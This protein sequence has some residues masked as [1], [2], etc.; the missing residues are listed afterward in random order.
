MN[1]A[2][3]KPL[4]L[5]TT[6]TLD[7]KV[8]AAYSSNSLGTLGFAAGGNGNGKERSVT[9]IS[10]SQLKSLLAIAQDDSTLIAPQEY[11]TTYLP[12]TTSRVDV[13]S[14]SPTLQVS[15]SVYYRRTGKL[16]FSKPTG[17]FVCSASLIKPGVVVTAAHCVAA[18]GQKRFYTN[19]RFVPAYYNGQAPYGTWTAASVAILPSYYNGTDCSGAVCYNDIAVI[20]LA[21]QN[22]GYAG[23][24]VGWYGYGW[25][26]Y[27]FTNN[28]NLAAIT[29]LGYPVSHDSGLLMQRTDAESYKASATQRYNNIIGSR[30]TGGASGGP[31]LVN[32]G[33][34]ASLS[35]GVG[36]GAEANRNVVVG[37]TSWGYVDQAPK[38]LGASPFTSSNIVPLVSSVCP[39]AS[40]PGC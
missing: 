17:N 20:K 23:N 22:G 10:T 28:S 37:V 24:L 16:F 35:Q 2:T 7:D 34:L 1:Y 12:F 27:G 13:V 39:S 26:G 21:P 3:A 14:A 38:A 18:Y 25:D 11:G 9:L 36:V 8:L 30:Q 32:F 4:A 31:W 33:E 6:R 15:K 19:F 40:T 5:P 29:Q